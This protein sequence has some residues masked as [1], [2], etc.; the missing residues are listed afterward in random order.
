MLE[1]E[2]ALI[3]A[4]L[5]GGFAAGLIGIGGGIVF[6]PVL[7]L[8]FRSIGVDDG[9][10]TPLAI[11]TSLLCTLVT[12]VA[13]ARSHH[14][15]GVVRPRVA[16]VTGVTSG[17]AVLL[18]T[19]FVTTRPWY[20]QETFGIVF[21]G[22]LLIVAARMLLERENQRP[23]GQ[24]EREPTAL[25]LLPLAAT[26]STAGF[27]SSAV[28]VGGGVVLV[29]AYN[30]LFGLPMHEAIGTSSATIVIISIFGVASY[31]FA[32]SGLH[33]TGSA[34]GLVDPLRAAYLVIPAVFS[35]RLGVIAAHRINRR[36]LQRGFAVFAILV[37][38]R[39]LVGSIFG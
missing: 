15:R 38:L 8:Y 27:V 14:L 18:T 22:V 26:G 10:V 2:L 9:L 36:P 3:A 20:D 23:P 11:G 32:G 13:S 24:G 29:P 16:I 35:A 31:V 1:L 37:A 39:I 7:L 5:V 12:S 21:S 6:A 30:R 28:G 34:L 19:A 33:P 17:V 4:G 25:R